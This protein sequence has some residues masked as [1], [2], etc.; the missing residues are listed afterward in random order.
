MA[1]K[2]V[3]KRCPKCQS[4]ETKKNGK[5]KGIQSY[6]Y[7]ECGVRFSSRRKPKKLQNIIFKEYFYHKQTL[8]QLSQKYQRSIPW[9]RK[10]DI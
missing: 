1:V 8:R 10:T 2:K 7:L 4:L 3:K 6:K 5:S 9:I